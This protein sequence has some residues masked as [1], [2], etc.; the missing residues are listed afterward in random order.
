MAH[1]SRSSCSAS[2]TASESASAS[3]NEAAGSSG[4]GAAEQMVTTPQ[5]PHG[6]DGETSG[7]ATRKAI[8]DVLTDLNVIRHFRTAVAAASTVPSTPGGSTEAAASPGTVSGGATAQGNQLPPPLDH[9]DL[10]VPLVPVRVRFHFLQ[11]SLFRL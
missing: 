3:S 1:R 11:V 8:L 6:S 10:A 7:T 9:L 2:N 4:D 5:A